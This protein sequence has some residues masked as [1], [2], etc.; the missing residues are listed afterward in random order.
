MTTVK[1]VKDKVEEFFSDTSRSRSSTREGL[2]DV[3]GYIDTLLMSLND[4]E[5]EEE[6]AEDTEG[7]DD[8]EG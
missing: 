4:D 8:S 2:E 3:S 1:E 6:N 5:I 7:Q